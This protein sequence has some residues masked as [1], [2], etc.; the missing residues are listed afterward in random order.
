MLVRRLNQ[1]EEITLVHNRVI[2]SFSKNIP[3]SIAD[4]NVNLNT[5]SVVMLP[6]FILHRSGL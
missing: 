2:I 5:R 3:T 4:D 1:D 6:L